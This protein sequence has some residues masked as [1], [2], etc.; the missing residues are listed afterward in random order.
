[1]VFPLA[2]SYQTPRGGIA[3]LRLPPLF[4]GPMK[5]KPDFG[6]LRPLLLVYLL[7]L[8][9]YPL[10]EDPQRNIQDAQAFSTPSTTWSPTAP[11]PIEHKNQ[12]PE[13]SNMSAATESSL[14]APSEQISGS[15]PTRTRRLR[16][17]VSAEALTRCNPDI[18]ITQDQF[19]YSKLFGE[20]TY[21]NYMVKKGGWIETPPTSLDFGSCKDGPIFYINEVTERK[22]TQTWKWDSA[23]AEWVPVMEGD[24]FYTSRERLLELDKNRV[25]RLRAVRRSQKN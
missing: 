5:S 10:V 19:N 8:L 23:I 7:I 12:Q 14:G 16:R 17:P 9:S 3:S 21:V 15:A 20:N 11:L 6:Q 13:A 2:L 18:R 22:V 25:P 24:S 1:M 4:P